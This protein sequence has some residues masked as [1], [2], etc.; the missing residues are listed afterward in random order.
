MFSEIFNKLFSRIVSLS[1]DTLMFVVWGSFFVIF[2]LSFFA[3]LFSPTIR[4]SSKRPYLCIL[5]AYSALTM[6]VFLTKNDIPHSILATCAFWFTGYLSYGFLCMFTKK[7]QETIEPIAISQTQTNLRMPADNLRKDIPAAKNSVRLEHALAI[8]DKL[9]T[10]NLG[11]GD[12]QEIEKLKNAL[13]MLET[14]GELTPNEGDILNENFNSLLK[15][16]AKYN[17]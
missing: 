4:G 17:V 7:P 12:R 13:I 3:C 10:K 9:L 1:F 8:I 2:V 5:N 14:R 15:L 6:I 16:M 11:K